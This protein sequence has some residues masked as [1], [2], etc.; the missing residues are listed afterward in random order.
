MRRPRLIEAGTTGIRDEMALIGVD[1]VGIDI[2]EGKSAHHIIRLDKVDLR[3]ALI[4]KQSMLSL[5]GDAAL[6]RNAAGLKIDTTPVILMGTLKQLRGLVSRL[7]GQPFGLSDLPKPIGDLLDTINVRPKFVVGGKNLIPGRE[8]LV[9]GIL[10]VTGDSFYDGGKYFDSDAA[11]A[12]GLEMARQGA[13]IIDVG[14]ESTRP[15]AAPVDQ[16]EELGRVLPVI[17]G[18][19]EAGVR[20]ISVDTTK[21]AVAE[22][23][24]KAGAGII[25]DI[26]GMNFDAGMLDVAVSTGAALILMHTR[27]RPQTMQDDLQYADLMGEVCASLEDSMDAALKAGIPSERICLDPGIGFGKS[28]SQNLELITRVREIKSFGVP[29]MIGASRKSFIGGLTGADVSERKSGSIA[30]AVAAALKGA[31]LIRVHDVAETV[32]AMSVV[33]GLEAYRN[34]EYV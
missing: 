7:G 14:G 8:K 1:P 19:A 3:A 31:D 2:M 11:V 20:H 5:G 30:A 9:V 23:A 26:S 28:L 4:L 18:L 15:G 29:V 25:N 13:D 21:S 22:E 33:S 27:G 24:V 10:N 32:Q 16:P 34:A 6:T 12:R 17:A